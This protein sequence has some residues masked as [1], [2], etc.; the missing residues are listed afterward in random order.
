ML[1]FILPL[2]SSV[3]AAEPVCDAFRQSYLDTGCCDEGQV[4]VC[5]S[6]TVS[7]VR[8]LPQFQTMANISAY[9][10]ADTDMAS[11][12]A[13]TATYGTGYLTA[14]TSP[15]TCLAFTS[16]SPD[17]YNVAARTFA[18][19]TLYVQAYNRNT[20]PAGKRMDTCTFY[21]ET[22]FPYY[23]YTA[24]KTEEHG[25][26]SNFNTITGQFDTFQPYYYMHLNVSAS[27]A[28]AAVSSFY[29]VTDPLWVGENGP[30]MTRWVN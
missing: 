29:E 8:P 5:K 6:P 28:I 1:L 7:L 18:F 2:F 13:W 19:P 25:V 21:T 12:G 14:I 10:P 15:L 23:G 27:E 4:S 20:Q 22:P 11:C 3:L 30:T 24:L 17:P 9:N 16:S 26:C